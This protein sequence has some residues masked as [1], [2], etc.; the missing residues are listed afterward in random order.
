MRF[1]PSSGPMEADYCTN[2]QSVRGSEAIRALERAG[3]IPR[4]GKGNHVNI[5]MPD[6]QLITIPV[7]QG[8]SIQEVIRNVREAITVHIEALNEEGQVP[9]EDPML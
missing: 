9:G 1:S 7:S 6:G 3:G 8:E 4:K 2:A 5:K